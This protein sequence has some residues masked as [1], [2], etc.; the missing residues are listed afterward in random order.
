MVV[1][2]KENVAGQAR[3][4]GAFLFWWVDLEVCYFSE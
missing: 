4:R 3:G 2:P 1:L